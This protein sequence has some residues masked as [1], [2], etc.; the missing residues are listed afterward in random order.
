MD[1][2]LS[3]PNVKMKIQKDIKEVAE[4]DPVVLLCD[5]P[6]HGLVAGDVGMV[7]SLDDDRGEAVVEFLGYDEKLVAE[8]ALPLGSLRLFRKGDFP[9]VR[10]IAE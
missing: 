5:L 8:V 1:V 10:E 4:F 3:K 9:H 6:A 2:I 7:Q